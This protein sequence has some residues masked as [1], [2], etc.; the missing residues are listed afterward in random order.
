MAIS[1][2]GVPPLVPN[3]FGCSICSEI[4]PAGL[5]GEL[6]RL[7]Q[8]R[9]DHF[10]QVLAESMGGDA[11]DWSALWSGEAVGRF[12]QRALRDGHGPFRML[13][14]E[15]RK[16]DV[17]EWG[18]PSKCAVS[19]FPLNQ[20]TNTKVPSKEHAQMGVSQNGFRTAK[21]VKVMTAGWH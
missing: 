20:T 1:T 8:R 11:R 15:S 14:W 6:Q 16:R 13:T 21:T 19:Y 3:I 18:E 5:P 4:P 7:F 10:R 12:D 2:P 17:S 9:L